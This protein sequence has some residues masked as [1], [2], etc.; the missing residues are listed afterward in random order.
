MNEVARQAHCAF[1]IVP[2]EIWRGPEE[3]PALADADVDVYAQSQPL[4][5]RP[6]DMVT[7]FESWYTRLYSWRAGPSDLAGCVR[8]SGKTQVRNT[9]PLL[10]ET[11]PTLPIF[12]ALKRRGWILV[13]R[14]CEHKDARVGGVDAYE[15]TRMKTY[16]QCVL[17]LEKCLTLTSVLPSRQPIHF[18]KCLLNGLRV[19]PNQGHAHYLAILNE[20]A[21][22]AGRDVIEDDGPPPLEDAMDT[23]DVPLALVPDNKEKQ[24]KR[25]GI[26]FGGGA[27]SKA[28]PPVVPKA[29][30]PGSS[31]D[32]APPGHPIPLPPPGVPPGPG[33]G[34]P[35][36]GPVHENDDVLVARDESPI[37]ER[38]ERA[39]K[40]PD[41]PW[42]DGI[43]GLLLRYDG[44]YHLPDHDDHFIPN[45]QIRCGLEHKGCMK[46]RQ[47]IPRHREVFGYIE[48]LAYLHAWARRPADPNKTHRRSNPTD[49]EVAA[50]VA[51]HRAELE[52]LVRLYR[53]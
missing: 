2:Q 30:G 15:S 50:F 17:C 25:K 20:Q 10:D 9:I 46:T 11:C 23:D 3:G 8:L 5:L 27:A 47:D 52:E 34:G 53:Y 35:G 24:Q 33:V 28:P 13:D 49:A 40:R 21:V 19:E 7:E 44:T 38:R 31:G 48:P 22:R 43:A 37:G 29:R 1:Q 41:N 18:Y 14:R 12:W 4:W 39:P 6:R 45:W 36:G 32:P 51:E 16:W 42:M 26:S